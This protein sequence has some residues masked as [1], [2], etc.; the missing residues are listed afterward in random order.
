MKSPLRVVGEREMST[1]KTFEEWK[2][3]YQER[4]D[5]KID[6]FDCESAW[7]AALASQHEETKSLKK[8]IREL[9]AEVNAY[10]EEA[11]RNE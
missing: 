8:Q 4:T 2:N 10:C 6:L 5:M 9:H 11:L 7:N 1:P 3:E